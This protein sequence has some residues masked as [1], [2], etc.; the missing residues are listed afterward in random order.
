MLKKLQEWYWESEEAQ[1]YIESRGINQYSAKHFGIG[2]DPHRR[3]IVT[4]MFDTNEVCIGLIGRS[5]EGKNFKNSKGLPKSKTLWNIG[6]AKRQATDTLVV[7]ESNFDGIRA[8]QAGY[9]AVVATLGSQFSDYYI[10]QIARTF[11]KVII[12]VDVDE[13]GE[14]FAK[15][16][17]KLLNKRGITT[18]RIQW[19]P[20]QKLPPGAKDLGDCSDQDIAK[21]L[22]FA[23]LYYV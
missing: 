21:A 16:I 6:K 4:P 13:A 23:E 12:A 5:I 7:V 11:S 8:H 20:G 18:Y 17:A 14:S 22:K 19:A 9:P 3:T 10:T 1:A 2:Y 15:R